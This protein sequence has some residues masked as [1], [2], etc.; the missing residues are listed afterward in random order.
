MQRVNMMLWAMGILFSLAACGP[1]GPV[2]EMDAP[3]APP[4]PTYEP[5]YAP[6]F[7]A[8]RLDGAMLTLSEMQG[9]WVILNF[10]A[11]DCMPCREEMPEL[12]AI[13]EEYAELLTVWGVNRG[14]RVELVRDFRDE[15]AIDFPILVNPPTH[16]LQD[17]Q[18]IS[19]PQT[20]IVDPN[21]EIQWR[22][23][24]PID[25][26]GFEQTFAGLLEQYEARRA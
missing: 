20:V 22:Q 4:T 23:F 26:S 1:S 6:D 13:A 5:F 19:L 15:F 12:Q 3:T 8:Q 9:Q 2:I 14:E 11:T 25:L 21:G 24:G 10:W 16:A 17:Y 7:S 18:V